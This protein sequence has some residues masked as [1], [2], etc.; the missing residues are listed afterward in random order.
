MFLWRAVPADDFDS[1]PGFRLGRDAIL[2]IWRP[3]L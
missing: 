3:T 1:A 2:M